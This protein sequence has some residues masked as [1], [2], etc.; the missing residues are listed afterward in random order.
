MNKSIQT[1]KT[2]PLTSTFQALEYSNRIQKGKPSQS[3]QQTNQPTPPKRK[4][5]KARFAPTQGSPTNN[6][7]TSPRPFTQMPQGGPP[8][9]VVN[10]HNTGNI[11]ANQPELIDLTKLLA[12]HQRDKENV[13]TI[14]QNLGGGPSLESKV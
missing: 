6:V 3:P 11:K 14:R 12:Q 7:Y 2:H 1:S 10:R 4:N 8:L 13:T 9:P 5:N